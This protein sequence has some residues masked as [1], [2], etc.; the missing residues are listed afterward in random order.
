M[1]IRTTFKYTYQYVVEGATYTNTFTSTL[2]Q[3]SAIRH[4]QRTWGTCRWTG[5]ADPDF[6]ILSIEPLA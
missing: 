3:D 4:L 6:K 1:N 2:P 5:N